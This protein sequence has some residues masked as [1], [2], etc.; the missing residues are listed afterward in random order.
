MGTCRCPAFGPPP[1]YSG[2]WSTWPICSAP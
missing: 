1:D 2:P